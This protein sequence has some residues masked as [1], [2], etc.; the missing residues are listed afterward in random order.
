LVENDCMDITDE[1]QQKR[2]EEKIIQYGVPQGSILRSLL[3]LIYVNDIG[4]NVSNDVGIKLTLFTDDTSIS[5]TGIDPKDLIFNLHRIDGSILTCFDKNILIINK[6]KSLALGFHHKSNK[7]IVFP[8][9]I[10]KDRQATYAPEIKFLGLWLENNL[11]WDCHVE[12]LIVKLSK[13]CFA[14]KMIKLFVCKNIAKTMYF[15]YLNSSLKYVILG[16]HYQPL[17]NFK[18]QKT[19]IRLMP[20]TTST[21]SCKLYFR[22]LKN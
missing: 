16:K 21:T 14:I 12:N 2:S 20:N 9:I 19:A 18:L 17:K 1:I 15:A 22:K 5:I 10:L 4:T 7:H 6:D 13:L 8:D 11:N 3:L